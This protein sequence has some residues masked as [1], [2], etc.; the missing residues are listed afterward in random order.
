MFFFEVTGLPAGR[1]A[2]VTRPWGDVLQQE[3]ID[4]RAEGYDTLVNALT[5]LGS[6]DA[7]E[8]GVVVDHSS[9]RERK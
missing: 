8:L 5:D 6:C 7:F 3:M 1:P 4:L 9:C 2:V